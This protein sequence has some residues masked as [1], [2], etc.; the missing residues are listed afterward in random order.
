MEETTEIFFHDYVFWMGDLNFRLQEEYDKTPE[1]I[2][3]DIVKNEYKKLF[4]YDQLR[5]VMKK[6][7]AFSE[8]EEKDP[9]FP[10]T[11]K[12]EVG[13]NRYDHK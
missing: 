12:F 7:E 13:T 8:L 2:E 6:G 5:Y 10:P 1:E 11:F 4:T 9:E 3:R